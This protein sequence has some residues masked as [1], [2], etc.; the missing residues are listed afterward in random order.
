MLM[1]SKLKIFGIS[2]AIMR[3]R[4]GVADGALVVRNPQAET[5]PKLLNVPGDKTQYFRII[6]ISLV[7]SGRQ[8]TSS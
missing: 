7:R 8:N 2:K 3:G 4:K 5:Q 1:N 6:P